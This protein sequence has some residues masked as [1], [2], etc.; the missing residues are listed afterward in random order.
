MS[1]YVRPGFCSL[2]LREDILRGI[3]ILLAAIAFLSAFYSGATAQSLNLMPRGSEKPSFDCAQAK[4]A[5]ARLIC[6]DG[7]LAALDGEL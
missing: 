4:T 7:E 6:A 3:I 1:Y 5:A 2:V